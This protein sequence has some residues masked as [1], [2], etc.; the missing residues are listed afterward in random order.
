MARNAWVE[1]VHD[2]WFWANHAWTLE[3]EAASSGHATE[4]AEFAASHPRPRL[5]DFMRTLSPVWR[6]YGNV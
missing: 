2:A 4:L 1:A 3:A 5:G 6:T